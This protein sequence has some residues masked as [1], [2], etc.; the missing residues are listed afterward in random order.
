MAELLD[1]L[2][3]GV[4][5][6]AG[7]TGTVNRIQQKKD[8]ALG[9]QHEELQNQTQSI[10]NNVTLLQQKRARLDPQSPTY[11]QDL[12]QND[13]DL[14]NARQLMTDLYHPDRN[15]DALS[16]LGG[17]IKQHILRQ[18]PTQGPTPGAMKQ[19]VQDRMAQTDAAA[20]GGMFQK[21]TLVPGQPYQELG[22]DGQPAG[23]YFR[24]ERDAAGNIKKVQMPEGFRPVAPPKAPTDYRQDLQTWVKDHNGNPDRPTWQEIKAY[25][26]ERHMANVTPKERKAWKQEP[27]GSFTSVM[28]DDKNQII[29][30][31]E[32]P[33]LAPPAAMLQKMSNSFFHYVDAEGNLHQIGETK[34]SGPVRPGGARTAA[35][36]A[37]AAQPGGA[38][39]PRTP[40]QAKAVAART[41]P[42]GGGGDRVIGFKGNK[43]YQDTVENYQA[44]VDRS[45]LM[46]NNLR[47][48]LNGNQ[49]AMVSLVAN[50]VGMT[51]GAQPGMRI[52]RA[53][54]EEAAQSAPWIDT[55]KA[56]WFHDD[57]QTGDLI[58]D[59][60]KG[61]INLTP[62]QMKQMVGLAHEKTQVFKDHLDRL[63]AA[64]TD[65]GAA[66]A[67][68]GAGPSAGASTG[69]LTISLAKAK[70]LPQ[71]RG[72]S[73]A[74]IT[75]DI[76][77]HGHKVIP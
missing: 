24:N 43:D 75:A 35:P 54:W 12:S 16:K 13:L 73:D 26:E 19:S 56:K 62:E 23:P 6:A 37:P 27:D 39:I 65:P 7:D 61:G 14:H 29:P 71:N 5:G 15:P 67:R 4:A 25:R 48:A 18:Q 30:G 40:G 72:K 47:D 41:A 36:G 60:F 52:T 8:T 28:L 77:A 63:N 2:L 74:E 46:D 38:N 64:R 51:G 17:F 58:F 3:Q 45:Q 32:N 33:D 53:T 66:K 22:P 76:Q 10:L 68:A 9:L 34:T 44:A 42:A 21:T 1:N 55:V 20:A 59:G 11:Q 70:L 57:P 69:G 49:Q 50:H 31:T